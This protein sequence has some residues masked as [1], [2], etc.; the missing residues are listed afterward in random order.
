MA[1]I[2]LSWI[3]ETYGVLRLKLI[4]MLEVNLQYIDQFLSEQIQR[5][6]RGVVCF[7]L[8]RA[9]YLIGSTPGNESSRIPVNAFSNAA[10]QRVHGDNASDPMLRAAVGEVLDDLHTIRPLGSHRGLA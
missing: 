9:G 6:R 8:V 3:M 5:G 4:V 2:L 7:I 1:A 10:P